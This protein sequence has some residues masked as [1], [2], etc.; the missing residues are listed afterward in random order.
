MFC[1]QCGFRLSS[2]AKFCGRCGSR[3]ISFK[4][5]HVDGT[6]PVDL[7]PVSQGDYMKVYQYKETLCVVQE[8]GS[9]IRYIQGKVDAGRRQ[10][11]FE[12]EPDNEYDSQAIAVK[13]DGIRIGYVYRGQT[14]DMI[15]DFYDRGF[16]VAAHINTFTK[17]EI[18][19][20]IGFYKP[21]D[22]C[23]TKKIPYKR[24]SL[25]ELHCEGDILEVEYDSLDD[26]FKI[27]DF[28]KEFKLP[29]SVEDYASKW[30]S[31][32]AELGE[33]SASLIFYK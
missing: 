3:V 16:E 14:Q 4:S 30:H 19:Y 31:V 5:M 21:K 8:Q 6:R 22:R 27:I 28:D 1:T 17:D 11:E 32:P 15:H 25:A 10:I 20:Y 9:P 12:F 18:T 24:A 13:L 29:S 2:S 7:L 33:D 26:C 23:R